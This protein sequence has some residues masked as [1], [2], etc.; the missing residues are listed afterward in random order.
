MSA[1]QQTIPAF[2]GDLVKLSDSAATSFYPAVEAAVA[3]AATTGTV[4]S[5]GWSFKC[6]V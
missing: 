1:C 6:E 4:W 2:V 3:A 5:G